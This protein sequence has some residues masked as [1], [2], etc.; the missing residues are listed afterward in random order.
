MTL[1]EFYL[2]EL[3]ASVRAHPD[4][5]AYFNELARGRP[6]LVRVDS[7]LDWGQNFDR[8]ARRLR[9]RGIKKVSLGMFGNVIH[10]DGLTPLCSHS[11]YPLANLDLYSFG[12]FTR[13]SNLEADAQFLSFLIH[14]QNGKDL[15]VDDLTDQFCY[16]PQSGVQVESGVDDVR[17]FEQQ[18][19]NCQLRIGLGRSDVHVSL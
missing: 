19:L 14:Q 6:E 13:V 12:D 11:S 10:E 5:I 3:V 1:S 9:T 7:D 18:R 4:Y 17:H 16:P 15:V 2:D 8:L